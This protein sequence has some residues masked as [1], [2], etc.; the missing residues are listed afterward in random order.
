MIS[1]FPLNSNCHAQW[2][3]FYCVRFQKNIFFEKLVEN[4]VHPVPF[5][6]SC[7]KSSPLKSFRRSAREDID[8]RD[9]PPPLVAIDTNEVR[10][11][12]PGS[13]EPMGNKNCLMK[14]NSEGEIYL[15][16]NTEYIFSCC[17]E[18]HFLC[19]DK[20]FFPSKSGVYQMKAMYGKNCR[21]IHLYLQRNLGLTMREEWQHFLEWL[22]GE[23]GHNHACKHANC[24]NRT[25]FLE[26]NF[27][28][29]YPMGVE[30]E[31][32]PEQEFFH[33]NQ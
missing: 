33:L 32:H 10:P 17:L 29:N 25:C 22:E 13:F 4:G 24:I 19:V 15:V 26:R 30:N 2:L 12:I 1:K 21:Q 5:P 27:N 6:T 23:A 16:Y 28:L 3:L 20:H 18:R 31:Y 7:I 8:V 9:L 11:L 14:K